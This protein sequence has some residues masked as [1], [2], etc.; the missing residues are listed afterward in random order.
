M[1]IETWPVTE[2]PRERL[3]AHGPNVLTDAELLAVLLR[4]GVRGASSLDVARDLLAKHRNLSGV[5]RSLSGANPGRPRGL[6][7][8]KVAQ[9]K[10]GVEFARRLLAEEIR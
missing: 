2:R 8:A 6:G 1:N 10:A 7:P 3:L 5:M 4:V 9:L